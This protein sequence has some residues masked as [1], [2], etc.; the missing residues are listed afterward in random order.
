MLKNSLYKLYHWEFW[1]SFMFYIPNVPYGI[2][3][4]IKSR[5]LTFFTAVNPAI[6][7][8]GNGTESKYDTIKLIPESYRPITLFVKKNESVIT[9]IDNLN[10]LKLN[11]PLI[12]KPDVGFKG[13]LVKQVINERELK[14]YL[15]KNNS[16]NLLIQEFVDFKN[17]CGIFYH[18]LPTSK[19]GKITSITLKTFPFVKGDG[20]LNL[21]EL[22]EKD[23]RANTY[24]HLYSNLQHD[25]KTVLKN[26][27]IKILNV[28]GNHCKG[29]EFKNGNHLI[30]NELELIFD[31]I[32][33]DIPNF[34][35]GRLDIK[36][37]S[38]ES[39]IKKEKIKIIEINGI[40]SEPTHIYDASKISYFKALKEIR[41]HW[42]I[43]YEISKSNHLNYQVKF[44]SPIKFLKSLWNLKKYIQLIKSKKLS[45]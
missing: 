1:P 45:V 10:S 19:T 35:Y 14:T 44:S 17:E 41:K 9:V 11:Y 21:N 15:N 28:L 23:K 4:A 3:L 26:G 40:I 34:Y 8:S 30:N 31:T 16:I 37:D 39:L 13:L 27:E 29:A 12:I 25:F 24:K 7:F 5:S 38:F 32:L 42:K 20:K 36:Y 2:Y 43:A 33:K 18:R 22:I 6:K